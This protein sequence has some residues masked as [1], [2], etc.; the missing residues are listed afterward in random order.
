MESPSTLDY[1]VIWMHNLG[2]LNVADDDAERFLVDDCAHSGVRH[3]E[4]LV[5][6]WMGLHSLRC[7]SSFIF[8]EHRGDVNS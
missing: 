7:L 6:S 1:D 4:W 5:G 3:G 2:F 8:P